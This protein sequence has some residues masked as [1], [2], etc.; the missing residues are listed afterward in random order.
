MLPDELEH[1]KAD[2]S[3]PRG[4]ELYIINEYEERDLC[5]PS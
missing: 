2:R 5:R 3:V 1:L 4:L